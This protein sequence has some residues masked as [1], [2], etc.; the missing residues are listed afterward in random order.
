MAMPKSRLAEG[1]GCFGGPKAL[2]ATWAAFPS[3]GMTGRDREARGAGRAE[4]CFLL[5]PQ[6]SLSVLLA[7]PGIPDAGQTQAWP[8]CSSQCDR[9]TDLSSAGSTR[10]GAVERR[11][12][13][14]FL[15]L[16]SPFSWPP[17]THILMGLLCPQHSPGRQT[18][19]EPHCTEKET[20]VR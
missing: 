15:C 1:L 8:L 14:P 6:T 13:I 5:A 20:E 12:R 9:R 17:L 2:W 11:G 19:Q 16:I 7:M 10:R 18:R 4:T 3:P